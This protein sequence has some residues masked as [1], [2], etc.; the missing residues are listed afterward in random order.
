M[1]ALV[2]S[3]GSDVITVIPFLPHGVFQSMVRRKLR[4]HCVKSRHLTLFSS[5]EHASAPARLMYTARVDF[6]GKAPPR[7]SQSLCGLPAVFFHAPAA[8]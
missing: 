8:C 7:T 3:C 5:G 1:N 2:L 6:G 4:Q